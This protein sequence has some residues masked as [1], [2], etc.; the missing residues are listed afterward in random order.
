VA[1]GLPQV[2]VETAQR[3]AAVA[4]DETGRVQA[5]LFVADL[6]DHRQA[7]QRLDAGQEDLAG[8]GR[9][10]VVEADVFQRLRCMGDGNGRGGRNRVLAEDGVRH[11]V[12]KGCSGGPARS[13]APDGRWLEPA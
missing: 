1:L 11:G 9:V 10:L 2:F 7:H 3:R 5:R 4:R 8:G 13:V 12:S 6:L